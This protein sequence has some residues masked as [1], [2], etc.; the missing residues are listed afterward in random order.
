MN[1]YEDAL[2]MELDSDTRISTLLSKMLVELCDLH[3]PDHA[4]Q[5]FASLHAQFPD[6]ERTQLAEQIMRINTGDENYGGTNKQALKIAMRKFPKKN[7]TT[8]SKLPSVFALQQNYPNPFNPKTTINYQLPEDAKVTIKMYD[9]LGREVFTLVD[10]FEKAGYKQIEFNASRI[11]SG[12]YFYKMQAG[13]FHAIRKIV[14]L[15]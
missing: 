11:A 6:D 12:V 4:E 7:N 9:L 13:N 1:T 14:L 15:K 3:Y 2:T 5:T 10:G 8:Q